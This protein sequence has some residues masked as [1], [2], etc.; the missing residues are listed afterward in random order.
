MKRR[1]R[2]WKPRSA[3]RCG[4]YA[5]A[6][7][8]GDG[9][10]A[11]RRRDTVARLAAMEARIEEYTPQ[12]IQG[13]GLS[14]GPFAGGTSLLT[15]PLDE[16]RRLTGLPRDRADVITGGACILV[17]FMERWGVDALIVSDRDNLEGYLKRY[18]RK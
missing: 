10:V 8:G 17:G 15:M 11:R 16:K 1:A 14:R 9:A 13:L 12:A 7:V 2:P 5:F 4:V 18:G 3:P 6:R